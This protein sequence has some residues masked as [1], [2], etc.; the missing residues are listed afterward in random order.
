MA[1]RLVS[2]WSRMGAPDMGR[3]DEVAVSLG[4]DLT[5]RN[6]QHT[7]KSPNRSR[8]RAAQA[9]PHPTCQPRRPATLLRRRACLAGP[10]LGLVG[11]AL[12]CLRCPLSSPSPF[13]SF[14]LSCPG[15]HLFLSLLPRDGLPTPPSNFRPSTPATVPSIRS[16]F[17][18]GCCES[19]AQRCLCYY[20]PSVL[21]LLLLRS[22]SRLLLPRCSIRPLLLLRSS[23]HCQHP[24]RRVFLF[25]H[26]HLW[27]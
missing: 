13:T 1:L 2:G 14:S 6:L 23:R 26:L 19:L 15:T 24:S 16:A 25:V 21:S 17:L 9:A 5:A 7:P 3:V 12:R 18:D 20:F 4:S 27:S 11:P 22:V 8:P 10:P